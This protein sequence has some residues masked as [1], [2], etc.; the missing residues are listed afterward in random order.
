M[1]RPPMLPADHIRELNHTTTTTERVD[2]F[3]P[4]PNITEPPW[5]IPAWTKIR[6]THTAH[7]P[8]LLDQLEA[9]VQQ[10]AGGGAY[11]GGTAKSK[12]SARLDAIAVLQRIDR[13]SERLAR[14]LGLPHATLRPRLSAIAGALT[15]TTSGREADLVRAW[16]VAARCTTGWEDAAY[17]PHV[18]CPNVDCERWDTL[19][20]R[21]TDGIATCIECGE[22]W[23][24]GNFVQL[25]DYIRWA[26]EHLTGPRHWLYDENGYPIECT[27]CLV[28]RQVMAERAAARARAGKAAG[29]ALSV[30]PGTIAS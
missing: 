2:R 26:A 14:N 3:V 8:A 20:I 30:V 16:W 27:V 17:T 25:G 21:L 12:P 10:A 4:I 18:P 24:E 22:S 29:R 19:R 13:Q 11:G 5:H 23:H 28:E 7:H 1:T 6:D 9:A 15:T